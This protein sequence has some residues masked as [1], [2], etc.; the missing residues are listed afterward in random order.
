MSTLD[1]PGRDP[2]LIILAVAGL[3]LPC[4]VFLAARLSLPGDGT[5]IQFAAPPAGGGFQIT[6]TG[7][8]GGPLRSGDTL[9]AVEGRAVDDWLRSAIVN[10]L[11][12][13]DADRQYEIRYTLLRGGQ[14]VETSV[15]LLREQLPQPL[16]SNWS[17]Y[18]FMLS[19]L[20]VG[21]LVF[22]QRPAL[23]SAQG[24][25]LLGAALFSSGAVFFLGLQASDLLHG[26]LVGLWVWGSIPLY[27]LFAGGMVHYALIFPSPRQFLKRRP[28][29]V[30]LLYLGTWAPA[31]V[32]LVFLWPDDPTP[33]AALIATLRATSALT[34]IAFPL[35]LGL[36][37]Y[38]YLRVFNPV[39]RR[40]VRWL[41]FA[42]LVTI[43]PW[44]ALSVIPEMLA[45]EALIPQQVVGLLWLVLPV[46]VAISILRE[47]LFDVDLLINR[48]LVYGM[49]TMALTAIYFASVLLFQSLLR[50]LTEQESDLAIVASTLAIAVSF[51]P[52]RQRIQAVIDRRFYRQKYDAEKVIARFSTVLR[53]EVDLEKLS[54][55]LL[56]AV[57][58]AMQPERASLWLKQTA[59]RK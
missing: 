21:L 14:V 26:W 51:T 34:A 50:S 2:R 10:P 20:V 29:L 36:Q 35:A 55:A 41:V 56:A 24:F 44:V 57:E 40:Q 48:T 43:A 39:E 25:L 3:L 4:F 16:V 22:A 8:A 33:S 32:Y 28:H 47:R 9:I 12:P 42:S 11:R 53:D 7:A 13:V 15:G 6:V 37:V 30:P 49:L 17:S 1:P 23:P 46:G 19:M 58:E 52:L 5:Q 27:A 18:L 59:R 45:G 31:A 38:G 54:M